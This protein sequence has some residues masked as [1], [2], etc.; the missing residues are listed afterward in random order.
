[1]KLYW[2]PTTNPQKVRLALEE[3]GVD[4]ERIPVDLFA[5]EH[6]KGPLSQ[7][8]PRKKVPVLEAGGATLYES[9]AILSWLGLNHG[10]WPSDS[11]EQADAL[12]L[13]FMESSAFQ[14]VA[15][16]FFWD[17]VVLPRIGA[18]PQPER[19][20]KARKKAL[21]LLD[22]LEARLE[23]RDWLCGDLSVVDCAYAVWLPVMELDQ[24]PRLAALLERFR[25]RDSWKACAFEY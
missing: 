15:G 10:L 21:P 17:R 18:E 6:R 13:L 20:E 19:L 8:L 16:V 1:M 25:E 11:V 24:H 12:T 7:R 2:S 4:Y 3:L 22:L 23:H 14:D 9:G 5:G